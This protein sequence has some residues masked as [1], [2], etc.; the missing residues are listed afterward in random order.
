[1]VKE[2]YLKERIKHL[3]LE[4]ASS[5]GKLV[6]AMAY[7]SYQSRNLAYCYHVFKN[8]L[9][10]LDRPTI[11]LGL[12]GAMVPGGMRKIVRDMIAYKMVDVLVSTG[13]NLYHDFCE[14]VGVPHYLGTEHVNDLELREL[15]IDRVYDTFLDEDDLRKVDELI[16]KI[17]EQL[18]P[19][20]YS[21]REYLY[22]LGLCLSD[23]NSILYSA[24]KFDVPVFC[25]ALNDSSI[26]LTLSKYYLERKNSGKPKLIIDPIKDLVELTQIKI[27]SKKT[28]VIFIGGGTPKNYVQQLSVNLD[29]LGVPHEGH[30]YAIQITTDDPKWGGLSGC[31]FKEAKSWGKFTKTA[32]NSTVYADAT[33][34]LPLLAGAILQNC[35]NELNQRSRLKFV[36]IGDELFEIKQSP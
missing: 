19:K 8:M 31:T 28:G 15:H 25:P 9:I 13:A 34:A 12:A 6:E 20:V 22:K 14:A 17:T 5:I 23:E 18:E 7:T 29:I 2:K 35:R 10:D 24:S 30:H 16:Y 32:Y 4:E 36:W 21:T 27:K 1:M 26:G 33:I 3:N 11:F